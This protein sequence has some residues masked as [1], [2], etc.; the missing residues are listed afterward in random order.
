MTAINETELDG[1]YGEL[2]RAISEVGRERTPLLLA[3]FA[4]LAVGEIG[5]LERVRQM[6]TSARDWDASASEADHM[7]QSVGETPISGESAARSSVVG[8][9]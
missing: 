7:F 6:L 9:E 2:C 8:V 5:D 4:L 3:R 1:L